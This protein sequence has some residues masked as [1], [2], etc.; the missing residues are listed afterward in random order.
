LWADFFPSYAAYQ[1]SYAAVQAVMWFYEK[2]Y[3]TE[4]AQQLA[5]WDTVIQDI[6]PVVQRVTNADG[7]ININELVYFIGIGLERVAA[8]Y[9]QTS[10]MI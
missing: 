7:S 5:A 8:M 4:F 9:K 10:S 3:T 1:E 6:D 2:A